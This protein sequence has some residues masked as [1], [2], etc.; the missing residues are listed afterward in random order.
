MSCL[1][2]KSFNNFCRATFFLNINNHKD[3]L[4]GIIDF[5]LFDYL[6]VLS[7]KKE[8]NI[9]NDIALYEDAIKK[10]FSK[11]SIMFIYKLYKYI[12]DNNIQ[13]KNFGDETKSIISL[14]GLTP[15]ELAEA[16]AAFE[17]LLVLRAVFFGVK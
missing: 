9:D 2:D 1:K 8:K 14:F 15:E 12:L 16:G 6:L 5:N 10:V 7:I 3:L 17:D 11:K 4:R 13:D